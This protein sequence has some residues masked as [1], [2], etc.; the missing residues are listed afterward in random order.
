MFV[1]FKNSYRL[2][3]SGRTVI[4]LFL[5]YFFVTISSAAPEKTD[6]YGVGF[7]NLENLFDTIHDKGKN[8]YEFLP[9]GV[10]KWSSERYYSKIGCV[11]TVLNAMGADVLPDGMAVV[12]V[13]EVENARV[14]NDLVRHEKLSSRGWKFVHVDG[15][16]ER[17]VDCAL[18]Y[19]PR[20]FRPLSSRLV[21][22]TSTDSEVVYKSRGFLV[23]EGL[24]GGERVHLIVNHWPSRYGK[25]PLRERAGVL[26]REIKDSII[27]KV[28]DAK[29]LIMGDMNDN[30]DD[31]SMSVSL[32]AMRHKG[33]VKS[34]GDLYNPWWDI[35][36]GNRCG[37][38]KYQGKWNLYDQIVLS[39]NLLGAGNGK[40]KFWRA[41]VF[42]RD[43]LFH[44]KGRYKGS[45]KRT[46]A[47]NVWLN[48]YSDHL[49]VVV[50]LNNQH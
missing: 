45:L 38:Y 46:F 25:S 31:R 2:V 19:N 20:L 5:L 34:S 28:H 48:G 21:P 13:C 49:P 16:D 1:M 24:L 14:L 30:P 32:G 10:K 33:D 39:A 27:S 42:S 29:V 37:S 40:L 26:V 15:P 9:G 23:V 35:Y 22:Y 6:I 8:D 7:Y 36:A 47:G 44:H 11:A 17:G 41:E 43:F 12:G 18:L 50:Y 4:V 3:F